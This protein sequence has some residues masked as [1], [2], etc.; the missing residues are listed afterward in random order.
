MAPETMSS[1]LASADHSVLSRPGWAGEIPNGSPLQHSCLENPMDRGAWCST[2][3][4]VA[5]SWTRLSN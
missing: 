1:A 2:V 3:H 5:E 4:R